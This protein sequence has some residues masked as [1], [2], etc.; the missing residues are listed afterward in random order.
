M[1]IAVSIWEDK[2][3]PVLDTAN[4][5]LI[6]ETRDK[7][8]MSRFE[9]P[10]TQTDITQRCSLIKGLEIEVLICGAVSRQFLEMLKATGIQIISGISGLVEEALEAYH[11]GGLLQSKFLMPGRNNFSV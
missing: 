1:R 10:L 2:V 4:R 5:L 11:R 7:T 8:E 9:V 3:S 6:V